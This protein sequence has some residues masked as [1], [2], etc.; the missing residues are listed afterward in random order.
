MPHR[1]NTVSSDKASS[2]VNILYLCVIIGLD[3]GVFGSLFSR[4]QQNIADGKN[5]QPRTV[6]EK[7]WD[8][9][10]IAVREDGQSLIYVDRL[11]LQENSF[12]AFDVL[13]RENRTVRN[14][15]Q[16]FAFA[17]HYVPTT[18]RGQGMDS[19]TIPENRRMIELIQADAKAYGI[20]TFTVGDVRQGILH[21]VGPEQ[22]ISQPGIVLAGADSHTSTHG[23]LGAFAFGVGSSETAHA[24][25][26]QGLWRSKPKNMLIYVEDPLPT[27]TSS[28]D[29]ILAIIREVGTA[30]GFG[31]VIEYAGPGIDALSVEQR[32]TVCNM[33]IEAGARAGLI[34]PDQKVFD[35][36]KGRP[37][38]PQDAAWDEAIAYW[39]TLRSDE[40]AMYD[41][42]VK[43][44]ARKIVPMVSWGTAPDQVLPVNGRVPSA[45]SVDDEHQ[46]VRISN[47]LEYMGLAP[48][49]DLQSIALDKVF[50]GSCTNGRIEDLRAAADVA[51]GRKATIPALVVP[52]SGLVKKQA[53]AEGLDKIFIE[54]GF[55]WREPGCSMCVAV[56]GDNLKPEERCASTSN[57][58]FE[59][60]QGPGGRTHLMSPAMAAA[61]AIAGHIIDV[62]ELMQ[63]E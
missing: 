17:D 32:M 54:A 12:H 27:G 53:E 62:R 35:Y 7:I 33:S 49:T 46:Q 23:A 59:G 2:L 45:S 30:G 25:A 20:D 51:K 9:H 36:V 42:V 43:I 5:M 16:A 26:T 61:A 58:N 8:D 3:S 28:K 37:F 39:R 41:K 56:N 13:R 52:G 10:V 57:R 21:V 48:D 11:L 55:Q 40:G 14:P 1:P 38:A 34:A 18:P 15:S 50:I 4:I 19:V 60:R 29:L 22:G 24:L 47:A 63:G 6:F 31:H 44:D